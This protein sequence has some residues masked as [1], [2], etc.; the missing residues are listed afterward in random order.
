MTTY[1]ADRNEVARDKA[2]YF[3]TCALGWVQERFPD[4]SPT[5]QVQLIQAY[6]AAATAERITQA[7]TDIADNLDSLG[8]TYASVTFAR[9][10]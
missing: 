2:E 8:T 7:L 1:M 10:S 5:H 6:V 4:A 3:M 9:E